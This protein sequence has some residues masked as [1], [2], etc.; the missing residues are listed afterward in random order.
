[1]FGEA[2]KDLV[3]GL[4]PDEGLQVFVL[5]GPVRGGTRLAG[6]WPFSAV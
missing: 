4:R 3:R 1:M 5:Y 6:G 2:F